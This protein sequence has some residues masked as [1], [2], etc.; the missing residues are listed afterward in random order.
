MKKN[1]P[2]H[3]REL[4]HKSR[5]KP[6][7]VTSDRVIYGGLILIGLFATVLATLLTEH[8]REP[9]LFY[10]AIIAYLMCAATWAI[11]RGRHLPNWQ[12]ALARIPLRTVGYGTKN[13]K[14]L[15]AAH[16][17]PAVKK[18][19]LASLMISLGILAG[20]VFLLNPFQLI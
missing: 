4:R 14:P 20:L 2:R 6:V 17:Q 8:W 13:G 16:D 15:E 7:K 9:L 18:A 11:Y 1:Q 3:Q 19:W 5:E 12:Q 10:L